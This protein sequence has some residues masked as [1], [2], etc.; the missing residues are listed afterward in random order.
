MNFPTYIRNADQENYN[1]ELNQNLQDALSSNGWTIPQLT[2]A[3]ITTISTSMP[4]GT[5]WYCT[6][7]SPPVYVGLI[8]GS[9]V[10]FSTTSFP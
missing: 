3:Q 7:H 4:D 10:Q 2:T 1:E 9:L 8:S 6:D 5:I